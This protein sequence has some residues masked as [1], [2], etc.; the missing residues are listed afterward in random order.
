MSKKVFYNNLDK[1]SKSLIG[2]LDNYQKSSTLQRFVFRRYKSF[3]I[4]QLISNFF[5]NLNVESIKEENLPYGYIKRIKESNKNLR[6]KIKNIIRNPLGEEEININDY[7]GFK[8][9]LNKSFPDHFKILDILEG[10]IDYESLMRKTNSKE[11]MFKDA[12]KNYASFSIH[13]ILTVATEIH[14]K[15]RNSFP[16]DKTTRKIIKTVPKE[17][18][19]KMSDLIYK[20]VMKSLGEFKKVHH[21]DLKGFLKRHHYLWGELTILMSYYITLS[22][23]IG[24]E[25]KKK[26]SKQEAFNHKSAALINIHA[27]SLQI[28]REILHLV[29]GGFADGAISRWRS[30]F[31]LAVVA[32]FLGEEND[33]MSERFLN[34][35]ILKAKKNA[36]DYKSSYKKLK[37]KPLGRKYFANLR[38]SSQSLITQY[39]KDYKFKGGFEW[40]PANC[41]KRGKYRD[42]TFRA[43]EA[44]VGME[45]WHPYYNLSS[46][47]IHSGAKG[48]YRVGLWDEA[49]YDVLL[50][51]RTDHGFEDPIQNTVIMLGIINSKLL[52]VNTDF[53]SIL[54]LNALHKILNK[55][56][57]LIMQS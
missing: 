23:E 16:D 44:H 42:R 28:S 46:D 24:E 19:P 14:I 1:I 10:I 34:H 48:F 32:L 6:K 57:E 25:I 50:T 54:M 2:L 43:L 51:G 56:K 35:E 31:E 20:E 17:L 55:I 26:A 18:M 8:T 41:L 4:A 49:Q 27:R 45:H 36:Y 37:Q 33:E 53:E 38:K 13:Q 3:V 21:K 12:G 9:E 52:Y 47:T 11:K 39:G 29:E 30:L 5:S 22:E 40:I 15:Q 7:V